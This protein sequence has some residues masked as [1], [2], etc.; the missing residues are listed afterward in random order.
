MIGLDLV[1]D[2]ETL[3]AAYDD[4]EGVTAAFNLNLLARINRELGGDFDLDAFAHKAVWNA[5]ESRIE[6][7]LE[8]LRAQTV[9][10]AGRAFRFAAGETLHTENSYK[11]RLDAF[12]RLA[13]GAGWRLERQWISEAPAFAVVILRA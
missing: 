10:V 9:H 1:K 13:A 3:V 2:E 12:A 8:S 6:M 4:A 5:R 11:F 7:H